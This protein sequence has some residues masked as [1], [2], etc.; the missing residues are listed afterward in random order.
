MLPRRSAA[1]LALYGGR[2]ERA[3]E[4]RGNPAAEGGDEPVGPAACGEA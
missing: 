4:H 2:L 3:E 1:R